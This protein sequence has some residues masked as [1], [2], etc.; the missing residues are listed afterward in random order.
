MRI[1]GSDDALVVE[2]GRVRLVVTDR[3]PPPKC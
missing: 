1:E 3:A 2:I